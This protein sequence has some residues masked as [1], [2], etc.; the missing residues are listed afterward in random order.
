MHYRSIFLFK[1]H[2]ATAE[3]YIILKGLQ[4]YTVKIITFFHKVRHVGC[5]TF[6]SSQ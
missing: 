1:M 6:F 5:H 4:A 3:A 2:Q